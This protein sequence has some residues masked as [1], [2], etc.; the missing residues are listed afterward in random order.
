M[1]S[2]EPADE[3]DGDYGEPLTAEQ[4]ARLEQVI[5]EVMQQFRDGRMPELA[6]V[7]D[8]HP[9][10]STQLARRL[11]WLRLVL[12]KAN[13]LDAEGYVESNV[14]GDAEED[15]DAKAAGDGSEKPFAGEHLGQPDA[16]PDRDPD[17]N[18][19]G[20][21]NG[22]SNR[23]LNGEANREPDGEANREPKSAIDDAA[24][25]IECP[26]C[27]TRL[28][29]VGLEVDGVTCGSCGST[30]RVAGVDGAT[31]ERVALPKQIGSFRIERLLGAGSCG[32]VFQGFDE[33]LQRKV[34]IKV[35]RRGYFHEQDEVELFRKEG[36]AAAKLQHPRIVKVFEVGEEN[37]RPYLVS[38]FIEGESLDKLM[39]RRRFSFKETAELIA[40]IADGVDHAH[41]NHVI[42]RDLKPSN[43]LVSEKGDPFVADFGLARIG[44]A[45][46]TI[47]LH[48]QIIGTPA[49]MSPEQARGQHELVNATSDVYSLGAILYEMLTGSLPFR[50]SRRM[51]LEQVKRMEPRPLR[52]LNDAIP[53]PLETIVLKTL[54][55]D[56]RRRY[57]SAAALADDL[58]RWLLQVPIVAR[59]A[60]PLE[61]FQL[62]CR[63]NPLATRLA[64]AL[65]LGVVIVVGL[66]LVYA[67]STVEHW[68][69]ERRLRLQAVEQ[70]Q[71]YI[72][73][74]EQRLEQQGAEL[75]DEDPLSA[76]LS[77]IA[78]WRVR[79]EE[80]A[81]ADPQARDV[82][83]YQMRLGD[84]VR[85]TPPIVN[86]LDF[87]NPVATVAVAPDGGRLA[88]GGRAGV[89]LWDLTGETRGEPQRLD[90]GNAAALAFDPK[91]GRLAVGDLQR[92]AT[93]WK[94]GASDPPLTL[95]D[96]PV[97]P[98][99]LDWSADGRW[100]AV[101]GLDGQVAVFDIAASDAV[102]ASVDR[103]ATW[104][105]PHARMPL[106]LRF[107]PDSRHLFVGLGSKVDAP[108]DGFLYETATGR[109]IGE[110]IRHSQAIR[111]A[112][113]SAD[114]RWVATGSE[115]G[116]VQWRELAGAPLLR[117]Q[118]RGV[119][120]Q[121]EFTADSRQLW[122]GSSGGEL[123]RYVVETGELSGRVALPKSDKLLSLALSGDGRLLCA[124]GELGGA[125]VWRTDTLEP[126]TPRLPHSASV[127]FAA[128]L[129]DN[130]RLLT[131][132]VDG[133]A[134][135][136]D[137]V[138]PTSD[139]FSIPEIVN[140]QLKL[141]DDGQVLVGVTADHT[142]REW[143]RTVDGRYQ[144]TE[145]KVLLPSEPTAFAVPPGDRNRLVTV[146]QDRL[147]RFWDRRTG[148]AYLPSIPLEARATEIRFFPTGHRF[149]VPLWTGR[150]VFGDAETGAVRTVDG[151]SER[152]A[153]VAISQSG[154]FAT[155]GRDGRL[156]LWNSPEDNPTTVTVGQ[157]V[158]CVALLPGD[159]GVLAGCDDGGIVAY[160][161]E[162][163]L[164][165]QPR[166]GQLETPVL[167]LTLST[168]GRYLAA[169]T[170]FSDIAILDPGT[171]APIAR[172][173]K[174]NATRFAESF[175]VSDRSWIVTASE[176]PAFGL[177]RSTAVTGSFQWHDAATGLPLT[178]RVT[179]PGAVQALRGATDPLAVCLATVGGPAQFHPWVPNRLPLERL[180]DWI[181]LH[182]AQK[183][184]SKNLAVPLS[185]RE[186]VERYE[187]VRK[188]SAGGEKFGT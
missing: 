53:R 17:G 163:R 148:A 179:Q 117:S 150:I 47:T 144:P 100:V 154:M 113:F 133:L 131:A 37:G 101:G 15:A 67:R 155:G 114:G 23:E 96:K 164:V 50:G 94:L 27:G 31:R 106:V 71:K 29:L 80:T 1:S 21:P 85:S 74:L 171:L 8:A 13:G 22:E 184:D 75:L 122:A 167:S 165:G 134:R 43:I 120:L 145:H 28:Q 73:Q 49:Y 186:I 2:S 129:P 98:R 147:L 93:L 42:H 132:T 4:T 6:A 180:S 86:L 57:A 44:E 151:H 137:V 170:A 178:R 16:K 185:R 161:L 32:T 56:G 124:S 12:E 175:F 26:Q 152:I 78:A 130:R 102:E 105:K 95:S 3:D 58:R 107:S 116:E 119:C 157:P 79:I 87:A 115:D 182:A 143:T 33:R 188:V 121:L 65:T 69:T 108:G 169:R 39:Q 174:G 153:G 92:G 63:R 64:L 7:L 14:G 83:R 110:P 109:V 125:Q 123:E 24:V 166:R 48:G 159:S 136:W 135:C 126:I 11:A 141:L 61:R 187:R 81:N 40:S 41:A 103:S 156:L 183:F 99:L 88:V 118:V 51:T 60:G 97:G 5:A 70:R 45:E 62:W 127:R 9:D 35:P 162:S 66:T 90:T 72:A 181:E 82:E 52:E 138:A 177:P 173:A 76:A 172:L 146:A 34:A 142:V 36:Q 54:A 38:D 140:G 25:R 10:L 77:F 84:I 111:A 59:P 18:R 104:L 168:D 19:D 160:S 91:G 112:A 89:R 68:S 46:I 176:R 55:K 30:F 128:W 20:N 158:N 139:D 149:I